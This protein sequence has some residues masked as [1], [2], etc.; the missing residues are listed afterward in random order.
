MPHVENLPKCRSVF[1]A[2]R[3]WPENVALLMQV[4]RRLSQFKLASVF[5]ISGFE[6]ERMA[7]LPE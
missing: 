5:L 4:L 2:V 1:N 7:Y 3:Y 6:V